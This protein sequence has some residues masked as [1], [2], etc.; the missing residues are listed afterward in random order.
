[1]KLIGRLLA[2]LL[3]LLA[4]ALGAEGLRRG[5]ETWVAADQ[6]TLEQLAAGDTSLVYV[7]DATRWTEFPLSG[8]PDAL[9]L[10]AHADLPRA[11][12][13]TPDA[14]WRYAV[15]YRFHG[16][17]GDVVQEDVRHYRSSVRILRETEGG[18]A[19]EDRPVFAASYVGSEAVPTTATPATLSL[20]GLGPVSAISARIATRAEGVGGVGLRV[21]Q[22]KPLAERRARSA[23]ARLTD[24]QRERLAAGSAYAPPTRR[25]A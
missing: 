10:V 24:T 8:T 1:M 19:E 12:A 6:E 23:W 3:A 22:R 4:L 11:L 18:T 17:D 25:A 21:Y 15:A 14:E 20:E 7:L 2:I 5:A 9:R 16:P 13:R